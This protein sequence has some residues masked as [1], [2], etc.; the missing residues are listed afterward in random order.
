MGITGADS[1]AAR[2]LVREE[3]ILWDD[4]RSFTRRKFGLG[5][6]MSEAAS[7]SRLNLFLYDGQDPPGPALRA[8]TVEANDIDPSLAGVESDAFTAMLHTRW[9]NAVISVKAIAGS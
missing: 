4:W 7:Q 2:D 6:G 5:D 3:I 1:E 9:P 8:I